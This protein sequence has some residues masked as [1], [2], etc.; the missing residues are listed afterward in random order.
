MEP[1]PKKLQDLGPLHQLLLRACP[2]DEN[3]NQS[4]PRLAEFLGVSHQVIYDRW[5]KNGRIPTVHKRASKLLKIA[6]GRITQEE[7]LPY[8]DL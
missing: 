6:N 7:L 8:L 5:I 1:T 2:P 4:I 3:G